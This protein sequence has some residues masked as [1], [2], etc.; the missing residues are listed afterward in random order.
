MWK[1]SMTTKISQICIFKLHNQVLVGIGES[2]LTSLH[3]YIFAHYHTTYL[4]EAVAV[5]IS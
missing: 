5:Y 4:I 3:V 1:T 2:L